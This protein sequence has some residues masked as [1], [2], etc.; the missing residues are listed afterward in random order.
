MSLAP[1][2]HAMGRGP[3]RARSLDATE[4]EDAMRLIL[5][6]Q[7]DPHAI[8]AL[9]MLMRYR[10]ETPEEIAGFTRAARAT[11]TALPPVDLDWPSYAAGRTRGLPWFLLAAKQVAR[12]GKRVLIHGWNS[13][14]SDGADVRSA[15]S[16]AGIA[17]AR[18]VADCARL[19][20]RDGIAYLPLDSFAPRLL[21]LLRLREVL[22]LRSCINTVCRMLNPAAAPAA[23]QGVFHPPY[24]ALQQAAGTILGQPQLC[25]LKGGG[26]EFERNPS[27]PVMLWRLIDGQ[28]CETLLPPLIRE[29]QRLSDVPRSMAEFARELPQ[30][31]FARAIVLGTTEAALLA[32]HHPRRTELEHTP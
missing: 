18:D 3:G 8:G 12:R 2:I 6:G 25:I 26:G 21:A 23:V 10:G 4:A 15:L 11:L 24:L 29:P 5:S 28:P 30:D 13:H 19:I 14:Q 27:K 32:T 7:A 20:D 16:L 17:R 22:G 1:Y 31:P 9:L